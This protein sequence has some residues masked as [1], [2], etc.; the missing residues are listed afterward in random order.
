MLYDWQK[1]C[2]LCGTTEVENTALKIEVIPNR[3]FLIQKHFT[4][5]LTE[6]D[7]ISNVCANCH[8]FIA[9]FERFSERC[10][11]VHAL[12]NSLISSTDLE[13]DSNYL[14]TLRYE[15]GLDRDEKP[16]EVDYKTTDQCTDTDDLV[17]AESSASF[18]VNVKTEQM[19]VKRVKREPRTKKRT[20][21]SRKHE[22]DEDEIKEEE[23]EIDAF[24]YDNDDFEND[25]S[26]AITSDLENRQLDED[27]LDDLVGDGDDEYGLDEIKDTPRK[28]RRKVQVPDDKT[29]NC[30]LCS[31]DFE[32][33]RLFDGHM[34]ETHPKSENPFSC[35][36]CPKRFQSLTKLQR[37]EIVH[38]PDELKLVHP[39]QFCDKRF[40]KLVNVQAHIRA[41]HTGDRP[42]ICEECGKSFVAKG[43]LKEHQIT[44]S[45]EYPFQCQH[46]PKKFKNMARLRTHEDIHKHTAYICPHCGLQLNT[47][48][49]LKMHMVVHSDQKKYKCQYC[50]N[51][52][53]RSKALKN[54]LILHTGLRPYVCPFCEKTFANGSNCRSHKKKAHPVELA[55]LEASGEVLPAANI[56]K[57][58]HLQPKKPA[59]ENNIVIITQNDDKIIESI[60][61]T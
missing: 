22:D 24:D 7:C 43:A 45:E 54:H 11:K 32:N 52:Y 10:S 23:M 1:W 18:V 53:K 60:V 2:R 16:T 37:H 40:S 56:P 34:R 46:C 36:K 14:Q 41:I 50:G 48:R 55:A 51:E 9:E 33:K 17:V 59:P 39:C 5:L 57:L 27:E 38:L 13:I 44:H 31:I 35:S 25:P 58:E 20:K 8:Q 21:K 26:F 28:R 42:F 19:T 49:T 15:A 29:Y 61:Y 12:F 47:K 4:V 6:F 3:I 30:P